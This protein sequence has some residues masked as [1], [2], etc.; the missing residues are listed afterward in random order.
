MEI[1]ENTNEKETKE[2]GEYGKFT[3]EW[4]RKLIEKIK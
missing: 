1:M 2:K 3:Q 4:Q